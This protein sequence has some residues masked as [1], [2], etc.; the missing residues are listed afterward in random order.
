MLTAELGPGSF[1]P[2]GCG[3]LPLSNWK[4]PKPEKPN[5]VEAYVVKARPL[6]RARPLQ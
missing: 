6:P 2:S 5:L 3:Y 4:L 1:E